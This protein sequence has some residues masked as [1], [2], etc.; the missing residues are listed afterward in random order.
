MKNIGL[1]KLKV[2]NVDN[3]TSIRG[4]KLRRI[5]HKPLKVILNLATKRKIIVESYPKLE[6]KVPYIFASTH[7]FDEDIISSLATIDRNAYVLIGTTDQLD[8]NPTMYAAW[9]NGLIYVDRLDKD[10]RRDSLKKMEKVIN[11]GS[12]VLM[13]PEG[14]WNNTEN[15]LIQ[16]LFAGPY[17]LSKST[18]AKVVPVSTFNEAGSKKIYIRF[19]EPI[20]L[21]KYEKKDALEHLRD[22]MAT[23]M[24]NQIEFYS[25]PLVRSTLP[26]DARIKFMEERKNEYLRVNWT[27]DVWE[28]E[29]TVYKDKEN[30]LPEDIRATF[31][32]VKITNK[33]AHIL[34][35]VLVKRL[36]DKKYN[37]K[38][39]MHKNWNN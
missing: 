18:G 12:S 23:M 4:M 8:Y 20:D 25:T 2:A 24:Y 35:P 29:L 10:S 32:N 36:E 27:R 28:E 34:T 11:N 19:G 30:P 37:F 38:D 33:N 1:G 5:I 21:G 31:D 22:S 7:S 16:K 14:G 17:Y 3:F 9:L 13:F 39:Y 26:Q 15:L 6:K